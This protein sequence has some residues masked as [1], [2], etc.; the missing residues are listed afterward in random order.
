MQLL[1]ATCIVVKIEKHLTENITVT[2]IIP[3]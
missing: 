3:E 2:R 1:P